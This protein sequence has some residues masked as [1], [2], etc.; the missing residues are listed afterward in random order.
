ME[1]QFHTNLQII[2]IVLHI[3][4]SG[5]QLFNHLVIPGKFPQVPMNF[6]FLWI[7]SFVVVAVV[8]TSMITNPLSDKD[9]MTMLGFQI[10]FGLHAVVSGVYAV[11]ALSELG[12]MMK[13]D[14]YEPA[15]WASSTL[16]LALVTIGYGIVYRKK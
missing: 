14:K 3:L 15:L 1:Q 13:L 5:F 7:V 10:A 16:V 4:V 12:Q 8:L 2:L 9:K 11:A 6:R